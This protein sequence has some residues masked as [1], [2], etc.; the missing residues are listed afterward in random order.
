[1]KIKLDVEA[2]VLKSYLKRYPQA[3][4]E[5]VALFIDRV[6]YKLEAE[7]KRAAPAITG[8]LRR[9]IFYFGRE[10]ASYFANDMSG[11][12]RVN[13]KYG[14]FVHGKPFY[15]NKMKRRET[16]FITTAVSNSD[17]FIK[18]ETRDIFN[19]VLE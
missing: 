3:M 5:S 7:S 19:R 8:N 9:S 13:A 11:Q 15:K 16:P 2:D 4:T 1:M 17:G 14:G 10:A 12:L 6:G 18:K